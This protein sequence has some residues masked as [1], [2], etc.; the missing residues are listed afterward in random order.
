MT[1]VYGVVRGIIG[2]LCVALLLVSGGCGS[3]SVVRAEAG[4]RGARLVEKTRLGT[5]PGPMPGSLHEYATVP[6][7]RLAYAYPD[8][9]KMMLVVDGQTPKV[10]DEVACL[11][12]SPKGERLG[13]FYKTAGRWFVRL[14]GFEEGYDEVL[15]GATGDL[16]FSND[17]LHVAFAL[18]REG[19]WYVAYDDLPLT[20][21]PGQ[22]AAYEAIRSRSL[23]FSRDGSMFAFMAKEGGCWRV[24]VDGKAGPAFDAATDDNNLPERLFSPTGRHYAYV[25]IQ[26]GK[27]CVVRDGELGPG[28]DRIQ[29]LTWSP[30]GAHVAYAA[31]QGS[32]G[33]IVVDGQVGPEVLAAQ[34]PVFSADGRQF[35]YVAV[36]ELAK[37]RMIVNGVPGP[38]YQGNISLYYTADGHLVGTVRDDNKYHAYVDGALEEGFDR[39]LD[40]PAFSPDGR[41]WG[42]RASNG[43][44][45][46]AVT[47]VIDGHPQEVC[48]SVFT[49]VQFSPD[50]KHWMYIERRGNEFRL[51]TD[52]HRGPA[53]EAIRQALWSPDGRHVVMTTYQRGKMTLVVDGVACEASEEAVSSF[54]FGADGTVGVLAVVAEEGKRVLY[55]EVW[56][57]E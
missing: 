11:Q 3:A 8:S 41:H 26:Q 37:C 53:Y 51:V 27:R 9:G 30:D 47:A 57:M 28:Y 5:L 24:V 55:R 44:N 31:W 40:Y 20:G 32:K 56:A 48:Q 21:P 1:A 23:Q 22:A 42:Y 45:G 29:E 39:V 15:H 16:C 49:P 33:F 4:G 14:E 10:Y 25:V 35:A 36:M 38:V 52:G 46:E 7:R 17:G 18:R 34:S 54:R 6:G 12:F 13:Y 19:K 2:S 43:M 50:S